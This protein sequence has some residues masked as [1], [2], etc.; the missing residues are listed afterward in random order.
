VV[1][2][3]PPLGEKL[4]AINDPLEK[5]DE[6]AEVPLGAPQEWMVQEF[7]SQCP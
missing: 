7:K 4:T 5:V 1:N 3:E 2:A 6:V